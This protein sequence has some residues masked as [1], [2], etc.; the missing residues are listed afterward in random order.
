MI[1]IFPVVLDRS[2]DNSFESLNVSVNQG[3]GPSS[4]N[5]V[6]TIDEHGEVRNPPPVVQQNNEAPNGASTN[7]NGTVNAEFEE[8][9]TTHQTLL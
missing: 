5:E 2:G 4:R 3:P 1:P 6:I 9:K 7:G 8:L